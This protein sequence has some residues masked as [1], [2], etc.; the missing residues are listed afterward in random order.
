M[1]YLYEISRDQLEALINY[2]AKSP[3]IEQIELDDIET[4]K[5]GHITRVWSRVTYR[6]QQIGPV[7]LEAG[8]RFPHFKEVA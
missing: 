8:K 5:R 4:D 2:Y 7:V 3:N 1:N 6:N